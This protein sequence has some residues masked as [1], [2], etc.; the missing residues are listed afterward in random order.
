MRPCLKQQNK[1]KTSQRYYLKKKKSAYNKDLGDSHCFCLFYFVLTVSLI[2]QAGLKNLCVAKDNL[3]FPAS[4]H[5]NAGVAD[6]WYHICLINILSS[7]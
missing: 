1:Q 2:P 3:K 4:C 6:A 5:P 7:I